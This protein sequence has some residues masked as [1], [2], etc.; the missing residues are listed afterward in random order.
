MPYFLAVE[1][2]APSPWNFESKHRSIDRTIYT[3]GSGVKFFFQPCQHNPLS[4][5][6]FSLFSRLEIRTHR[7]CFRE[8]KA[9]LR[10]GGEDGEKS[11]R[12]RGT[13]NGAAAA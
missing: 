2:V 10:Y 13:R 12:S 9:F 11:D 6:E 8:Q 7:F 3:R 5:R 1:T 4:K